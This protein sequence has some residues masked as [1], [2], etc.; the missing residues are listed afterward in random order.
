[1]FLTYDQQKVV[2]VKNDAW[3]GKT[4][5]GLDVKPKYIIDL[6]NASN[7]VTLGPDAPGR[8]RPEQQLP[9]RHRQHRQRHRRLRHP[10]L[11]PEA[12][13]HAVGQHGLAG[14]P[15]TSR[16]RWTIRSSAGRWPM[17]I[18]V[19]Q[20]VNNVYG[21][22]VK[23]ANPTGLLPT[24]DQ[25]VDQVGRREVRLQV[26]PG[27]G[28]AASWP[29][30]GYK[31]GS[32]GYFEN[33]DGSKIELELIVPTAGRTGWRRSSRSP[34]APRRPGSRSTPR[35]R[36][37]TIGRDKIQKGTFDLAIVNDAQMT[38]TPGRTTTGCSA[39]R[40]RPC[41]TPATTGGTRTRSPGACPAAR[42]DAVT[43]NV[44][45]MKA[46]ISQIQT[47]QL[48]DLPIIPLW[49]NGVWSQ[50][51]NARL[52]EL[53]V[54]SDRQPALRAGHVARLLEHGRRA[55]AHRAEARR[56]RKRLARSPRPSLA[57]SAGG[58]GLVIP[59]AFR[60]ASCAAISR[61]SC[62]PTS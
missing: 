14:R 18:D 29:N 2:W 26:R 23:A 25:F 55:H 50:A 61:G 46:I 11:L 13:V 17:S 42:R 24:W 52:D 20:I 57:Q 51:S 36:P 43:S 3:W 27:R 4:L 37:T 15:T 44:E 35:S 32:D 60:E 28:E 48:T 10:D 49:Y 21:N 12:A 38:N 33:K 40:S 62:S 1:M 22:I 5:L 16:S 45:A 8:H 34:R 53:A 41:R 58:T 9:A 39:S 47:I 7:N 6:V 19:S 30:A 56:P 31:M 59:V 54:R